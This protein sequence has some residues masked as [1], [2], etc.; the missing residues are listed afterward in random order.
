[1]ESLPM[2]FFRTLLFTFG[3]C[4]FAMPILL[5]LARMF[6]LYVVVRER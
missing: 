3:A 1:M 4:F 6:A 2:D 5:G